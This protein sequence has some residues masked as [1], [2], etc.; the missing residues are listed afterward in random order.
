MFTSVPTYNPYRALHLTDPNQQGEDVYGLQIALN[1]FDW[2]VPLVADGILGVKT[3][4]TITGAQKRLNL[5]ADGV[6]GQL[7]QEAL[8]LRIIEDVEVD[9]PLPEGLPEGQIGHESSFLLGNYSPVR[10]DGSFDAGVTQ[11]NTN[12]TPA[13]EG[14]N[15]VASIRTLANRVRTF[16]DS[17]DKVAN[18]RRRWE[19]GVGSWNA[20]AYANWI[21][22]EEGQTNIP[23]NA[24]RNP[25]LD[26]S[27][28]RA[29]FEAYMADCTVDLRL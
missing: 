3:S 14:F 18:A 7:T 4:K 20:W 19:L 17:Y 1:V 27:E 9:Y 25:D 8:V 15:P 28:A 5:T 16:H 23:T 24:R 13:K 10:E 21:A 26:G 11:R 6:A 29:T 22:W 2:K 12:F